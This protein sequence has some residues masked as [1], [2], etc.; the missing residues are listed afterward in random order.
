MN[1]IASQELR[2]QLLTWNKIVWSQKC[3]LL[4]PSPTNLLDIWSWLSINLYLESSFQTTFKAKCILTYSHGELAQNFLHPL[5]WDINR[6]QKK[7]P[8]SLIVL[9]QGRWYQNRKW[10]EVSNRNL[11]QNVSVWT[12]FYTRIWRFWL[13]MNGCML[14]QIHS[15]HQLISEEFLMSY[16]SIFDSN[17][18]GSLSSHMIK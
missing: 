9:G 13:G 16:F 2:L 1:P 5:F 7:W 8:A 10:K 11:L 17:I 6:N 3:R 4:A 12:V 15:E 18:R 14:T